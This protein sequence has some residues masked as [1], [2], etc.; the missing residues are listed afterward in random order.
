MKNDKQD[1]VAWFFSIYLRITT[2]SQLR[3]PSFITNEYN[4]ADININIRPCIRLIIFR[5]RYFY[6]YKTVHACVESLP[7]APLLSRFIFSKINFN[8]NLYVYMATKKFFYH[9]F[10]QSSKFKML[11]NRQMLMNEFR[12]LRLISKY[13]GIASSCFYFNYASS[14]PS[15]FSNFQIHDDAD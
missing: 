13:V 2:R 6:Y 1:T 3:K 7:P 11:I 9:A 15:D 12:I 8:R 10:D 14:L 5:F 4:H